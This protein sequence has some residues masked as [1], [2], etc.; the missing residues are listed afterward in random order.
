M[1]K[2]YNR[3]QC[4]INQFNKIRDSVARMFLNGTKSLTENLPDLMGIKATY[5]AYKQF[6]KDVKPVPKFEH[7][8]GDQSFFISYA[9]VS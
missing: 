5:L 4:L 9:N 2:Y 6:S 7:Y 1:V 8:N 3:S